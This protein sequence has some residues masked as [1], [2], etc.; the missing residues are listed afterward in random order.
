MIGP[1]PAAKRGKPA[2]DSRIPSPPA[3]AQGIGRELLQFAQ[4]KRKLG[5]EAFSPHRQR[6]LAA[7]KLFL[8]NGF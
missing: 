7:Q 4:K 6:E 2:G 3:P 5:A 8:R 1:L